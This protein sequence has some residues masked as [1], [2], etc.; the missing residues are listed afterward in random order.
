MR[1]S[2]AGTSA[3]EGAPHPG[4]SDPLAGGDRPGRGNPPPLARIILLETGERA[5]QRL[6]PFH[7]PREIAVSVVPDRV[8][9]L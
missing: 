4:R 3:P 2:S 7:P 5:L 1:R 8:F 6:T 9:P